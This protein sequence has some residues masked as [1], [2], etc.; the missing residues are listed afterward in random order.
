MTVWAWQL[1]PFIASHQLLRISKV[2][3]ASCQL[4]LTMLPIQGLSGIENVIDTNVSALNLASLSLKGSTLRAR[5]RSRDLLLAEVRTGHRCMHG[6]KCLQMNV[7]VNITLLK[8][9]IAPV[10][11]QLA[12][13]GMVWQ[14]FA[15]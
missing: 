12:S 3:R 5:L 6:P 10:T 11:S 4:I 15:H 8:L 2:Q 14:R 1:F 9:S 13:V 7:V